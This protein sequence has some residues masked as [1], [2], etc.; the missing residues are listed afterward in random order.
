MMILRLTGKAR[1]VFAI[2]KMMSERQ[3][4]KTLGEI[5]KESK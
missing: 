2:I 4:N 1:E 5:I 3:G